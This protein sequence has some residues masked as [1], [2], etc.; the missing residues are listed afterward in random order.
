MDGL[1]IFSIFFTL[2]WVWVI[3]EGWRAPM[4]KENEDGSFTTIRPAKKFKDLFK[5][6]K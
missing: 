1:S 4:M 6:K 3:Y 5:K 2:L